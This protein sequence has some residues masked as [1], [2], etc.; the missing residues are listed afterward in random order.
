MKWLSSTHP[1]PSRMSQIFQL[2]ARNW[3]DTSEPHA[4]VEVS[5]NYFCRE[6]WFGVLFL[7]ISIPISQSQSVLNLMCQLSRLSQKTMTTVVHGAYARFT[8]VLVIPRPTV[9]P[10]SGKVVPEAKVKNRVS[11]HEKRTE[12]GKNGCQTKGNGEFTKNVNVVAILLPD[13]EERV[14]IV[15]LSTATAI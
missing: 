4:K 6:Y 15:V 10:L 3:G 13:V 1:D 5:H 8:L 14:G 9:I 7:A 12:K 2:W 11:G